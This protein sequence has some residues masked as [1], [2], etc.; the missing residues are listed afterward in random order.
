MTIRRPKVEPFEA[1]EPPVIEEVT[2]PKDSRPHLAHGTPTFRGS[3]PRLDASDLFDSHTLV[4]DA[5]FKT[6]KVVIEDETDDQEEITMVGQS[7]EAKE[8]AHNTP[9]GTKRLFNIKF[10]G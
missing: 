5:T 6:P 3:P 1:V 8:P 10:D 4:P 7:V 9:R 2:V